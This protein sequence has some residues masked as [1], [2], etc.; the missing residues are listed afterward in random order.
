MQIEIEL[1]RGIQ[2]ETKSFDSVLFDSRSMLF[3]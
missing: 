3:L 2:N 1:K